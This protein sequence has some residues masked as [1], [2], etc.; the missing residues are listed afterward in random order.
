MTPFDLILQ[1]FSFELIAVRLH[2]KFEVS[3]FNRSRHIRGPKFQNWVTW[4][5]YDLFWPDFVFLSLELTA[6]RLHAKFEVSSFNRSR[7]IRGSQNSKIVSRDPH[8]TPFDLILYFLIDRL[9]PRHPVP[10]TDSSDLYCV[11]SWRQL[12]YAA[13]TYGNTVPQS[14]WCSSTTRP[15]ILL[16]VRWNR[17]TAA[18]IEALYEVV[19]S[20]SMSKHGQTFAI[21]CPSTS[22]PLSVRIAIG[23]PYLQ[24]TCSTMMRA[25]VEAS[26]L[27]AGTPPPISWREGINTGDDVD[28]FSTRP[29]MWSGQ[30]DV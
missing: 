25:T 23:R 27:G 12:R 22:F 9:G 6:I 14:R 18:F 8:M 16:S 13:I 19:C 15:I 11:T 7:D 26:L 21:S 17:S 28:W 20:L 10:S 30:V 3:S 24:I 2:A 5:P 1:F 4:P 29:R